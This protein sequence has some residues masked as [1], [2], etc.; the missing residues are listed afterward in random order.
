MWAPSFEKTSLAEEALSVRPVL[1]QLIAGLKRASV[2]R[3]L[4]VHP[5]M[6]TRWEKGEPISAEM[7]GRLLDVHAVVLHALQVFRP[8]IVP[9]WLLG[10]EP[11]FNGARPIDVMATRG[12]GPL[13]DALK[14]VRDGAFM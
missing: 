8:S 14:G 4:D 10:S 5:A 13:L 6:I 3:I 12:A 7:R 9:M 11:A 1:M 2:A